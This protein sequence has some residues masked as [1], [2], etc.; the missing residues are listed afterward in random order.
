MARGPSSEAAA[1][2]L[3]LRLAG[4]LPDAQLWRFRDWLAGGAL[5]VLARAVPRALLHDRIAVT[6]AEH[7]LLADAFLPHGGDLGQ[8][9]SVP[10]LDELAD[11]D[12]TFTPES[13]DRVPMGDS[14]TVVLGATLRGRQ[15]V[16]EVRS[17]W[18]L[19]G[20]GVR[21]ARRIVLVGAAEEPSRLAGELQRVLR[22]LGEHEPCVE[23]VPPG[24][25]LPPYHRAALAASELV[26][27]GAA[28]TEGHLVPG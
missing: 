19:G 18:R 4:R 20:S 2:E 28:D 7:R 6:A 8:V 17:C 14:A 25:D 15:G 10:G 27:T 21:E 3:L 9:S 13:P 12:Y 16:G 11:P 24:I 26:C 22:A 5:V 23:V 1:H